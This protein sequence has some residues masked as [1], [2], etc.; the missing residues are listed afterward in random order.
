[1][2]L[3]LLIWKSLVSIYSA[4]GHQYPIEQILPTAGAF[5]NVREEC[6]VGTDT[7]RR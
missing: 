1:M 5:V 7:D 6:V 2:E 3:S 4:D